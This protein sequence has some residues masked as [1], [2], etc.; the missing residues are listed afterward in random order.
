MQKGFCTSWRSPVFP[1]GFFSLGYITDVLPFFVACSFG[2]SCSVTVAKAAPEELSARSGL[3][4]STLVA[5]SGPHAEAMVA[6]STA[7]PN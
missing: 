2:M 1:N 6:G 4:Q 3:L 5:A 7:A